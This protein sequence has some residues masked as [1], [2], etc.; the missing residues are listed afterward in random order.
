MKI[1]QSAFIFRLV[2]SPFGNVS[3]TDHANLSEA[4]RRKLAMYGKRAIT[5][6]ILNEPAIMLLA[7]TAPI[8]NV[9]EPPMNVF[10]GNEFH[11]KSASKVPERANKEIADSRD[12]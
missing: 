11:F 3:P 5:P 10:A 9:P 12:P 1:A 6:T 8:R 4:R 2:I 7:R